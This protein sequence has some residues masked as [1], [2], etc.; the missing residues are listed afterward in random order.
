MGRIEGRNFPD[1]LKMQART[2]GEKLVT[3][4]KNKETNQQYD[5]TSS[6]FRERMRSSML[7]RRNEWPYEYEY[8]KKHRGIEA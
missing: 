2:P 3:A 8:W 7:R 1:A 4:W 6:Q 5:L